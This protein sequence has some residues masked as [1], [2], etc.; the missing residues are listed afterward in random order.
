MRCMAA[1]C[2]AGHVSTWSIDCNCK[3][4]PFFSF[5]PLQHRSLHACKMQSNHEAVTSPP[6]I[7]CCM[8]C[9]SIPQRI[10]PLFLTESRI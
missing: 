10:P 6:Q 9:S 1:I 3:V 7:T 5:Q 2:M 8:F 4:K